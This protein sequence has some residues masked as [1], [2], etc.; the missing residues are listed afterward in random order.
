M[1]TVYPSVSKI[2]TKNL[3]KTTLH[4]PVYQINLIPDFGARRAAMIIEVTSDDYEKFGKKRGSKICM[5]WLSGSI[6]F[7][8]IHM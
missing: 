8:I 1:Q 2:F 6:P 4:N 7:Q 5:L 3:V